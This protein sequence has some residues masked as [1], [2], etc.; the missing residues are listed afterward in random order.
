MKVR[1]S[2][3][4]TIDVSSFRRTSTS[5]RYHYPTTGART[6]RGWGEAITRPLA[7]ERRGRRLVLVGIGATQGPRGSKG[8]DASACCAVAFAAAPGSP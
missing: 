2:R 3:Y 4:N 7:L 6:A 1:I 8:V 5:I